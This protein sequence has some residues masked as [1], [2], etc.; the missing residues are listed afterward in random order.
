M[1]VGKIIKLVAVIVALVAGL[2][3][4]FPQSALVIAVLG[5]VTGWFVAEEDRQRFLVATI[6]LA[7]AGVA[8]GLNG[9]PVLG[10]HIANALG[11]LTSLLQAGAVTVILVGTYEK[12]KP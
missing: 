10:E 4:G 6:A 9:I 3:G 7:A 5:A 11:G 1:D 12:V 2:M 8:G